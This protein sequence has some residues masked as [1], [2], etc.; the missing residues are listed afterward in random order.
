MKGYVCILC[1]AAFP[2]AIRIEKT[3]GDPRDVARA[4]SAL[5]GVPGRYIVQWQALVTDCAAVERLI[6]ERLERNRAF[7]DTDFFVIPLHEALP[8]ATNIA[9]RYE[10]ATP[11]RRAR[12]IM[13]CALLL[14]LGA[15]FGLSRLAHQWGYKELAGRAEQPDAKAVEEP[16]M[17]GLVPQRA[18]AE[19]PAPPMLVWRIDPT[20]LAL[21]RSATVILRDGSVVTGGLASADSAGVKLR[22]GPEDRTCRA[23][24]IEQIVQFV[25]AALDGSAR[26]A[27]A[28]RVTVAF[29]VV[30]S[31]PEQ[32]RVSVT[33]TNGSQYHFRGRVRLSSLA[34]DGEK[35]AEAELFLGSPLPLAPG[36]RVT[37]EVVF[38]TN[39]GWRVLKA[40]QT[41]TF[42]MR[43]RTSSPC[44]RQRSWGNP[45]IRERRPLS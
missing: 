39:S 34:G 16:D 42:A 3:K 6:K 44:A 25:P 12:L 35:T 7:G 18:P 38:R 1:N 28:S 13:A 9:T 32:R 29:R 37:H 31:G 17:K 36:A 27:C 24:E 30:K 43:P 26:E 10:A 41:G 5:P 22:V 15:A 23:E 45:E 33:I 14:F 2:H 20:P 8:I 40:W 19:K 11:R 4:L 21:D